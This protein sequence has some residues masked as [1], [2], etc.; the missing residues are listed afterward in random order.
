M[1]CWFYHSLSCSFIQAVF[2]TV[3]VLFTSAYFSLSHIFLLF[4]QTLL[5]AWYS[6]HQQQN[7]PIKI[8]WVNGF[9]KK[10]LTETLVHMFKITWLII[11]VLSVFIFLSRLNSIELWGMQF[12]HWT[13]LIS[14]IMIS[15][16]VTVEQARIQYLPMPK[17]ETD[18]IALDNCLG[19]PD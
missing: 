16:F 7:Q 11:S 3:L 19:L 18:I 10:Y 9:L 8:A 2:I 15:W 1:F 4:K 14:K 6:Q 17:G 5:I 13:G 12:S